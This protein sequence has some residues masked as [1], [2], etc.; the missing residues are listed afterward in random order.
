MMAYFFNTWTYTTHIHIQWIRNKITSFIANCVPLS[1]YLHTISFG[2][3]SF[4]LPIYHTNIFCALFALKTINWW[5]ATNELEQTLVKC[6]DTSAKIKQLVTGNQ[7]NECI[8]TIA[9]IFCHISWTE[10]YSSIVCR[11]H[12]VMMYYVCMLSL[13]DQGS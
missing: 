3:L 6:D 8:S 11:S 10:C 12:D 7:A 5:M 9:R 1:R 13:L 4:S 2:S